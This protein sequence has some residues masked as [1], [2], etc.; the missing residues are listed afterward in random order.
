[1]GLLRRL[2]GTGERGSHDLGESATPPNSP[3]D[4]GRQQILG[5]LASQRF[6]VRSVAIGR[7]GGIGDAWAI[8]ILI[9]CLNDPDDG[10]RMAA[11]DALVKTGNPLA[12]RTALDAAH[13]RI[14]ELEQEM[15]SCEDAEFRD[16]T[17]DMIEEWK[18]SIPDTEGDSPVLSEQDADE[19]H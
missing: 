6:E 15:A 13:S 16:L 10:I 12:L 18:A 4:D 5:M 2:F 8:D 14:A 11:V 3:P 1:M 17:E 19:Q 9:G 7:L